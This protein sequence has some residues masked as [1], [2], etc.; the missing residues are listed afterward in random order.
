VSKIAPDFPDPNEKYFN[1]DSINPTQ[2][3]KIGEDP[4]ASPFKKN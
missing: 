3:I 2:D 1:K 4:N